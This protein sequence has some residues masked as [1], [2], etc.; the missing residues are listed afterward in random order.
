VHQIVV[1]RNIAAVR[2]RGFGGFTVFAAALVLAAGPATAQDASE[3]SLSSSKT[4]LVLSLVRAADAREVLAVRGASIGSDSSR[5]SVAATLSELPCSGSY[6]YEIQSENQQTGAQSAYSAL[7]VL[8][9]LPDGQASPCGTPLPARRGTL[10]ISLSDEGE[11]IDVVH[12]HSSGSGEFFGGFTT[13]AQPECEKRYTLSAGA[14]FRGWSRSV[15]Y[16]LKV[17]GWKA[18]AQGLPLES[19][20]DC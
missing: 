12:A 4:V 3:A 17:V 5:Y 20:P 19:H 7:V 1:V 6:R 15:R 8:T 14:E 16:R 10:H 2:R 11:P 13:T 18:E 9:P